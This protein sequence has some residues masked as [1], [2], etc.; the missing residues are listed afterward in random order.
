IFFLII[1]IVPNIAIASQAELT[2]LYEQLPVYILGYGFPQL[3][4]NALD[5]LS[6]VARE[7]EA[8]GM[9]DFVEFI[10]LYKIGNNTDFWATIINAGWLVVLS[11]AS[12]ILFRKKEIH[13]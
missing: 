8:K 6:I 9:Q 4:I 5:A 11:A 13:T 10:G 12:V 2:E 3:T 1:T 7:S